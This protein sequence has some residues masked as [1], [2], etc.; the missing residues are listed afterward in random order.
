MSTDGP[1]D[2]PL[3]PLVPSAP[4]PNEPQ[5]LFLRGAA[6]LQYVMQYVM[7][8]VE[9]AV[10]ELESVRQVVPVDGAELQ[11]CYTENRKYG[12]VEVG[13]PDRQLGRRDEEKARAYPWVLADEG[14]GGGGGV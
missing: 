6:Y 11:L 10:L 2:L 4:D 9:R 14:I 13:N 5:L 7:H 1:D 12:G 8:L 3:H